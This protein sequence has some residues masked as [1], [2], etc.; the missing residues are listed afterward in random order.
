MRRYFSTILFYGVLIGVLF[1]FRDPIS[2]VW[3]R[4]VTQVFPCQRP[5]T[6]SLGEFDS[7]F[8]ISKELFL[9]DLQQAES[10]W[11]KPIG[12]QLFVYAPDGELT[13]NLVYDDR[14]RSTQKLQSIGLSIRD[15]QATYNALKIRFESLQKTINSLKVVY[16]TQSGTYDVRLSAYNNEVEMLNRRGDVTQEIA[17]RLMKEKGYLDQQFESLKN[18]QN[19]VN[20][21]VDELNALVEVVNRL[22]KSLNQTAIQYNKLGASQGSEFAEGEYISDASGTKINIYQFDDQAK[23]IRVL[24]HELGHSLGLG[25][26]ENP[27]AIMYRLNNGVN[28]ALT[29][30]DLALLKK[31]CHIK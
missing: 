8:G 17:D 28:E 5:I 18:L 23:L 14:Q 24:T 3:S 27:K 22:A 25:H 29:P 11:E 13:V 31:Q 19:K 21:N 1:Y 20:A 7:R 15:D 12:K 16:K 6:Y 2:R 26:L 9:K 10:L 30:D 4:I